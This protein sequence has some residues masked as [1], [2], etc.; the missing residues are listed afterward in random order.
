MALSSANGESA[1]ASPSTPRARS[2]AVKRIGSG[3]KPTKKL[4]RENLAE[5]GIA[6]AKQHGEV[7]FYWIPGKTNPADIF[8]KEGNGI[9]HYCSLR[10]LMVMAREK[11]IDGNNEDKNKNETTEEEAELPSKA[12]KGAHGKESISGSGK[13]AEQPCA[14]WAGIAKSGRCK[15]PAPPAMGGAGKHSWLAGKARPAYLITGKVGARWKNS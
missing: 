12:L 2:L 3:C 11:F 6:E 8:T 1:K 5:L 9:Q 7:S 14:R 10:D 13:V 15:R 4:R